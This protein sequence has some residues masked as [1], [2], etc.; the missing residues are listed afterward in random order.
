MLICTTRLYLIATGRMWDS[1]ST[2]QQEPGVRYWRSGA[3]RTCSDS[4]GAEGLDIVGLDSSPHMLTVCRQRLL[5]EPEAIQ[6]SVQL[7][8]ADM[9]RFYWRFT[10][11]TIPFR[12]FQHLLTVDDQFACLAQVHR[13]L[14]DDGVLILDIFNP[15]LD[16]LVSP[17]R[18][19]LWRRT[20]IRDAGWPDE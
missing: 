20:G 3:D 1:S 10:L 15:S 5:D 12:P 8:Q 6:K 2:P 11:V 7:V 17:V 4:D 18:R 19:R 16:F 13:H 9:R 14:V